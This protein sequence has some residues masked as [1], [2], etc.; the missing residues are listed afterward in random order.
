MS[1]N[2]PYQIVQAVQKGK[3]KGLRISRV[4]ICDVGVVFDVA[5]RCRLP[6]N[7]EF[8]LFLSK[9]LCQTTLHKITVL[10][11]QTV[12]KL[13]PENCGAV[14][15]KVAPFGFC[16]QSCLFRRPGLTC[17]MQLVLFSGNRC[18]QAPDT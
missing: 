14:A 2:D 8:G 11:G 4:R 15:C 13:Y 3:E 18:H 7:G 16:R 5:C 10:L 17:K 9:I 6:Y 12:T 1:E